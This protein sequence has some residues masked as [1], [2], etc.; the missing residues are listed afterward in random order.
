MRGH[1]IKF[2]PLMK[3]PRLKNCRV[4]SPNAA[5]WLEMRRGSATPPYLSTRNV[6]GNF[7]L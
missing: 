6:Q 4:A 3:T 2:V 7:H 1:V 5:A